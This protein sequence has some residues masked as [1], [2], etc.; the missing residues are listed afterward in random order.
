MAQDI[1]SIQN[2]LLH[3]DSSSEWKDLSERIQK[4]RKTTVRTW[5]NAILYILKKGMDVCEKEIE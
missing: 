4:F 1:D 2:R 3:P 5:P